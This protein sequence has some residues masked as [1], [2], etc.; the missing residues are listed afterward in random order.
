MVSAVLMKT[1][2]RSR[3]IARW[4][5]IGSGCVVLAAVL[6]A[7]FFDWNS[8]RPAV[9]RAISSRTGR[10]AS[11]DGNLT[12]HLFSFTPSATVEGLKIGNPP[13]AQRPLM[14]DLPRLTVA[15]SLWRLVTGHLVI[16]RLE[17]T[18]PQVDVEENAEGKASWEFGSPAGAPENGKAKGALPTIR[19]LDIADGRIRADLRPRKLSLAGSISADESQGDRAFHLEGQGEINA[20][21]FS[22]HLSGGSLIDIEPDKP[23]TFESRITA[24]DITTHSRVTIPRPFDL[25]E[26][27]AQESVQGDDLANA[28]YLTGLALP[29]TPP[30]QVQGVVHRSGTK[31]RVDH[32]QG[33]LGGSD[34]SGELAIDNGGPRPRL[35]GSLTSRKLDIAD[36][37]VPLGAPAKTPAP[38]GGAPIDQPRQLGG[39]RLPAK[40]S[41]ADT[42]GV[43]AAS[44]AA[45]GPGA[46]SSGATHPPVSG[47]LLPDADLQLN[48]VRGMDAD[49]TYRAD[50][51]MASKLPMQAVR[52]HIRLQNGLLRIDPLAFVL[53]EGQIT[54][55]LR[56]DARDTPPQSALELRLDDLKLDQFKGSGNGPAPLEGTL[57][58]RVQLQGAGSSIHKFASTADGTVTLVVQNGQI[59]KTLA[60][61]AGID[62]VK[63]L[64]LLLAQNTQ[65]VDI[66]CGVADFEA[67]SGVLGVETMVIDTP[68]VLL[69]GRGDANFANEK[70]NFSIQGQPKKPSL[71]RLRAPVTLKGSLAKP[72]VGVSTEKLLAQSGA[73][74]AL[75]TLLTPFAA[76]LA[77]VDPG[78]AKNA[79]CA[80][81]MSEQEPVGQAQAQALPLR[82]SQQPPQAGHP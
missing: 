67:R 23:Y 51:V 56:I 48:R 49:V 26:F 11:I 71:V 52:M 4:I 63:G 1:S 65:H 73:A 54:G 46:A 33:H 78:L 66:R 9:A 32:L 40:R 55:S 59:S 15:I 8:L 22:I 24:G 77:F 76:V 64:G 6:F 80:A 74:A 47:G 31:Y 61:L 41:I 17:A 30:Y 72:A 25:T 5:G 7:V 69:T 3:H 16:T 50:S 75:G 10:P 57:L 21:P 27:T 68:D 44:V 34:I 12:V 42:P 58:G 43:E 35:T 82:K 60:E 37:A 18:G 20:K 2:P 28:F 70:L 14:L 79:N 19:H 45:P 62:V 13:W 39:T 38:G 29:N 81:L 53:P 36:L